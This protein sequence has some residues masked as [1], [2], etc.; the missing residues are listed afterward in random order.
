MSR[1]EHKMDFSKK[2]DSA[3][4][5]EYLGKSLAWLH[6]NGKRLGIKCYKVGGTYFYLK[7]DLDSWIEANAVGVATNTKTSKKSVRNDGFLI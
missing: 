7:E 6:Q 4:A 5:A 3:Q 1:L 2:F